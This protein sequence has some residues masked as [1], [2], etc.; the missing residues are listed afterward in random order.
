MRDRRAENKL[1][2]LFLP[3]FGWQTKGHSICQALNSTRKCSQQVAEPRILHFRLIDRSLFKVKRY[4]PRPMI[5][6]PVTLSSKGTATLLYF[7]TPKTQQL[8]LVTVIAAM[9]QPELPE[10]AHAKVDSMLSRK[11]GK[12]V[13]NYFSGSLF[14]PV[15]SEPG[16]SP[17]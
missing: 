5:S 14:S 13:A 3:F 8:L 11:F 15:P 6:F 12:E 2:C 9:P 10:P 1:R 16:S 7:V 4:E 17:V